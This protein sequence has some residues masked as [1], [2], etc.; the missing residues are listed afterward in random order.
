MPTKIPSGGLCTE[1][2][3]KVLDFLK[4][5]DVPLSSVTN[6]LSKLLMSGWHTFLFIGSLFLTEAQTEGEEGIKEKMRQKAETV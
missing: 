4:N 5:Q 2:V 3:R 6:I 1:R